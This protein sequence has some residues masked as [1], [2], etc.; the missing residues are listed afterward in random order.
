MNT[1]LEAGMFEA[2]SSAAVSLLLK[3]HFIL[4]SRVSLPRTT[5]L[6]ASEKHVHLGRPQ[7]KVEDQSY[8]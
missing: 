1:F 8:R 2:V 7:S 3:K 4:V 5:E 6:L